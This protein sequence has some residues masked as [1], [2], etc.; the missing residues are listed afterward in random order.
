MRADAL[1]EQEADSLS[2]ARSLARSL[3]LSLSRSLSRSFFLSL[4][5]S[6]PISLSLSLSIFL[7][8]AISLKHTRTLSKKTH[9]VGEQG[10]SSSLPPSLSHNLSLSFSL[11]HNLC[12]C[13]SLAGGEQ[14]GGQERSGRASFVIH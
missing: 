6:L 14:R 10:A 12:M 5:L 4:A 2:L 1:G 8:H 13:V 9:L 3:S 11:S 7:T